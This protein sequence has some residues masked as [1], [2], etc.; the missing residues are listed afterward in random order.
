MLP[1]TKVPGKSFL[2]FKSPFLHPKI[3]S[4]ILSHHRADGRI[5]NSLQGSCL[6]PSVE[7]ATLD[8]RVVS[9]NPTLG[10]ELP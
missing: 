8:L 3:G 10:I 1:L 7:H 6:T 5:K 9:S 2:G 4:M